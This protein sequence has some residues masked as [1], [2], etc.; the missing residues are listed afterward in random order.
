MKHL[1]NYITEALLKKHVNNEIEHV[2]LNL[3]S[4]NLWTTCNIGANQPQEA[5]SYY[6]WGSTKD[7]SNDFCDWRSAPFND[8]NIFY[9][10][11][12]YK[13]Y[14][15]NIS[16]NKILNKEYDIAAIATAGKCVMPTKADCEELYN[17]TNKEYIQNYN[18][19]GVNV[20]KYSSKQDDSIFIIIPIAPYRFRN[21]FINKNAFY[22]WTSEY[23]T[24]GDDAYC[25]WGS[26]NKTELFTGYR[27]CAFNVRGVIKNNLN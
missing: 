13:K 27:R 25:F 1:N 24:I 26:R 18:H 9:D 7:N 10:E 19:T 14:V 12:T 22:L 4:G 6:M 3:P 2:D 8:N 23:E 21:E 20:I 11:K 5:G 17:N 15:Y 16:T